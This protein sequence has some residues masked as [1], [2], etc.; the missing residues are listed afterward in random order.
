MIKIIGR[1]VLLSEVAEVARIGLTV[2]IFLSY[3][4]LRNVLI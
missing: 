2:C 4:L 3:D 1:A